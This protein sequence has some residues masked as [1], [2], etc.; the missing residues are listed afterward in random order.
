MFIIACSAPS[1]EFFYGAL[2]LGTPRLVIATQNATG[3]NIVLYDLDGKLVDVL[4]DGSA[5]ADVPKGLAPFDAFNVAVLV[6][7]VDRIAKVSLVDRTV[8]VVASDANLTGTLYQMAF[9]K[10]GERYFA[11]EGNTI[12]AF[13]KTGTR[14]GVPYIGTTLG[15][16]TLST[17][18]GAFVTADQRLLVANGVGNRLLIYNVS[19]PAA[20]TC[21]SANAGFTTTQPFAVIQHSDG[22][23]YLATNANHQIVSLPADGVGTPAVV[24]AA[25][26]AVIRNPT[27]LIEM[28]DGTLLVASDQTNS[29]ERIT[30]SGTYV[31]STSF[32][33]DVFT[34]TVTQM[35]L[36]G[37]E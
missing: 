21:I 1:G 6:D 36:I 20:A 22:N 14:V 34:G 29:I 25:N 13:T 31:G 26:I 19:N 7:G 10:A 16:C 18:R 12:E 11:I 2:G 17:P 15:A 23:L 5:V 8:G 33:K 4:W 3:N 30:T 35:L 37:G 24:W 32:I 9:D 28:P 27:A